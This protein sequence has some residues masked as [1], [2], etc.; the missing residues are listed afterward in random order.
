MN[1]ITDFIDKF[2]IGFRTAFLGIIIGSVI[3]CLIVSPIIIM[4]L[5]DWHV[6]TGFVATMILF[7]CFLWGFLNTFE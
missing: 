5:L 2:F 7:I 4:M 3:V 6:Y 1:E